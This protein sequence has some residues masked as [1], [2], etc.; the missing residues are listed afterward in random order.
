MHDA[1]ITYP[2]LKRLGPEGLAE[3][4]AR[5]PEEAAR[6]VEGAALNGIIGAQIAFGQML[7][8]GFGVARDPAAALRWFTIAAKAGDADAVT[9]LGRAHEFGWGVPADAAQAAVHYREA[10]ARGHAWAQFNLGTLLLNG[11]GV[12]QDPRAALDLFVRAARQRQPKAMSILGRYREQG[13]CHP[14][15][16]ATAG[17]QALAWYRRGAEG[18]DYRG[19][20]DYARLLTLAG[21][22]EAALP[23]FARA[24]EEGVPVF[25]RQVG[26]GLAESGVPEL[27]R[28]ALRA[29]ER[30]CGT[31]EPQDLDA[32][33]GAL[34]A[35]LG[36]TPQPE[37][38][39][40]LA[41][42]AREI[43]R[44]TAEREAVRPAVS[45]PARRLA[46][47]QRLLWRF[48]RWI[49]RA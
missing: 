4:M 32:Y 19:Q 34:A 13:W 31:G 27:E 47:P 2:A 9:M 45:R 40:R 42:Q 20:F 16:P 38:A 36:G 21:H 17:R 18:G 43:E 39:A 6:W 7:V 35:G 28:I 46:L 24:V 10:A 23:W 33:A 3:R 25:C 49:D 15:R 44:R 22:G 26:A 48:R 1:W 29:L 11:T 41:A 12:P 37:E 8:D 14:P 5:S 30:A